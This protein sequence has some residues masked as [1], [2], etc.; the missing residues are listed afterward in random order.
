MA[1]SLVMIRLRSIATPGTPRGDDPVAMM[2]SLVARSVCASPS[3]TST[4]PFPVRR[5]VPLIQSILFFLKRY[6]TPFDR[7]PT[8]RSLR[9]WTCDHVDADGRPGAVGRADRDAPFL[10][11]LHDLERV[12][13]LE[14]RLGGNAAPQETG[15]AERLLFFDDGDREPE[16]GGA[17]GRDVAAGSGADHNQVVLVSHGCLW[18]GRRALEPA[19]IG[20]AFQR[21][22]GHER[23]G[24]ARRGRR[25]RRGAIRFEPGDAS[26]QLPELV[27]QVP[28][29]LA[30]A[31]EP[32]RQPPGAAKRHACRQDGHPDK[33]PLDEQGVVPYRTPCESVKATVLEFAPLA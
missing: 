28:I 30:V 5:A 23:V 9:V 25:G 33:Y 22:Q 19:G 8:I 32:L 24:A 31:V 27:A 18:D 16:L 7:P 20:S 15:A 14:Q 1:S 29:R 6:S 3:N 2:I 4:P 17:D 12:R 11:L 10:R 13:V 21:G 26:L